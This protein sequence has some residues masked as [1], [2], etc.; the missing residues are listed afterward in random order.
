MLNE[1]RLLLNKGVN[2]RF[3]FFVNDSW[4][5]AKHLERLRFLQH[6][7]V[8]IPVAKSFRSGVL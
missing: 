5:I 6:V 4:A 7:K 3:R 1:V 2:L 8:S